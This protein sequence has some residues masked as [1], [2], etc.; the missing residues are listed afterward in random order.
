MIWSNSDVHYSYDSCNESLCP[1]SMGSAAVMIP[2][3][4]GGKKKS[5]K[6]VNVG[7]KILKS[8]C[9]KNTSVSLQNQVSKT[10]S[11]NVKFRKLQYV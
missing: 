10:L 4:A 5:L 3:T 11:I 9:G 6:A 7:Y 2:G 1:V 8:N